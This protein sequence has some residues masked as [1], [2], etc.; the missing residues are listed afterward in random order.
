[1]D[2]HQIIATTRDYPII[3]IAMA[4]ALIL[5]A[6]AIWR[7]A[8]AIRQHT[9]GTPLDTIISTIVTSMI[10]ILSAEGMF[11]MLTTRL[12]QPIP[13]YLAWA[14]CAVV[15]G[16]LVVLYRY[17]KQHN[18]QHGRPG[19]YG[20]AFWIVAAGGG[21]IVAMSTS[22][23]VEVFFRLA[24]P[25]SVAMLHWLK[26][27]ASSTKPRTITWLI[28]PTRILARLGLISGEEITIDA[29]QRA[30]RIQKLAR[31]AYLY[32]S[33]K[34][35]TFAQR[36]AARRLR[37]LMLTVTPDEA[38]EAAKQIKL[39]YGME[40]QVRAA[41]AAGQSNLEEA[42]SQLATTDEPPALTVAPATI[43]TP[44]A[45]P[46]PTISPAPTTTTI[47]APATRPALPS[48]SA[49]R[50]SVAASDQRIM[51]R[52]RPVFLAL[53]AAGRL[54]RNQVTKACAEGNDKVLARQA[55]RII[56]MLLS[57]LDAGLEGSSTES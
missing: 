19:P 18:E 53:H 50:P 6:T 23:A 22:S 57:E 3:L 14:V 16:L 38:A 5:A 42:G 4:T 9:R 54:N 34:S 49:T 43:A 41:M 48:G 11:M 55:N 10:L 29:T 56:E 13:P 37:A 52:Y 17:A 12:D 25:L 35:G 39:M 20:T 30:R 7:T 31:R 36:R 46:A 8:A 33:K 24:L 44:P 27:T 2:L 51:S 21:A 28:T 45:T 47:S 26:L 32:S 1:M 15:E 40:G